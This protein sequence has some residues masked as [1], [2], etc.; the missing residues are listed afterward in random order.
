MTKSQRLRTVEYALRLSGRA[1][2]PVSFDELFDMTD[3]KLQA[4]IK[5]HDDGGYYKAK[6]V[7]TSKGGDK[8]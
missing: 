1:G 5:I 7:I 6:E 8:I 4:Y 2:K 3:E